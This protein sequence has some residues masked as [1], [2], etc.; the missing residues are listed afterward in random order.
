MLD[1]LSTACW[2][3]ICWIPCMFKLQLFS[4]YNTTGIPPYFFTFHN[5]SVELTSFSVFFSVLQQNVTF[6][7][8]CHKLT[9]ARYMRFSFSHNILKIT[10][11][12]ILEMLQKTNMH[13]EDDARRLFDELFIFL[14]FDTLNT[15]NS[16]CRSDSNE[17]RRPTERFFLSL[18]LHITQ[19]HE[20][21]SSH[22][23]WFFNFSLQL[24]FLIRSPS[25]RLSLVHVL[26]LH[27]YNGKSH[28][29][30]IPLRSCCEMKYE[31]GVDIKRDKS[32]RLAHFSVNHGS[33][34]KT[35][36][37]DFS[38]VQGSRIRYRPS[39]H[40]STLLLSCRSNNCCCFMSLKWKFIERTWMPEG[41][42]MVDGVFH[43]DYSIQVALTGKIVWTL[44]LLLHRCLVNADLSRW[45]TQ[46]RIA[47]ISLLISLSSEE[48]M[49]LI[50]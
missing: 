27:H 36:E 47:H 37:I 14:L 25:T 32:S 12:F 45:Q 8:F 2:R 21:H 43:I 13:D 49:T 6:S 41:R 24:R 17:M 30:R 31:C 7:L 35:C 16:I 46:Q 48:F 39:A 5:K 23:W 34:R 44:R 38:N 3:N 22:Q 33:A 28:S 1:C 20:S 11:I 18:C 26:A 40:I 9:R 42:R 19:R 29:H 50:E 10:L 4:Y 15:V